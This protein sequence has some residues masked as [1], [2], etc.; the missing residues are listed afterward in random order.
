M[1]LFPLL[2]CPISVKM[3]FP[4][5]LPEEIKLKVFSQL[6]GEMPIAEFEQWLY[7]QSTALEGAF[8]EAGYLA[9]VSLDFS[10]RDIYYQLAHLLKPHI[11]MCE[12]E[13]WRLRELLT[14]FLSQ[15]GDSQ[16]LLYEIYKLYC[17][18]LDF[19]EGLGLGYVSWLNDDDW[20]DSADVQ[21]KERLSAF[22][23]DARQEAQQ[24]LDALKSGAIAITSPAN[25]MNNY[26]YIDHR[27]ACS[28]PAKS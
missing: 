17:Q 26:Q 1:R 16:Q 5:D 14:T 24:I 18:G 11:D 21:L 8:G 10:K 13:T 19:L 12:Y 28:T 9:L 2:G 4:K 22:L 20:L 6:C 7:Q 23:L 3:P 15:E 27:K 25:E